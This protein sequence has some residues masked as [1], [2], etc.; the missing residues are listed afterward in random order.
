M[1]PNKVVNISLYIKYSGW[2]RMTPHRNLTLATTPSCLCHLYVILSCHVTSATL[3][4][5]QC[6][7]I[8][9]NEDGVGDYVTWLTTFL[10]DTIQRKSTFFNNWWFFYTVM[11]FV[12]QASWVFWWT[13]PYVNLSL[14][15]HLDISAATS[16]ASNA[17]Q[18]KN[19]WKE[20][21][22][23]PRL[24]RKRVTIICQVYLKIIKCYS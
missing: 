2:S 9:G 7:H 24:K 5:S 17:V 23:R 1:S 19:M 3:P 12:M 13:Y 4:R 16:P 21:E 11:L 6:Y 18:S 15:L 22:I 10:T 20:S 8:I 14:A